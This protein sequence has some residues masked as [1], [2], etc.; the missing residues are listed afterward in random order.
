MYRAS[1]SV[2]SKLCSVHGAVTRSSTRRKRGNV[3][4]VNTCFTVR[5]VV[6][7]VPTRV[8]ASMTR[9][10][11]RQRVSESPNE[12]GPSDAAPSAPVRIEGSHATA[13]RKS[14]RGVMGPSSLS[15]V[16]FFPGPVRN[17][18]RPAWN[19]TGP[20]SPPTEASAAG[21]GASSDGGMGTGEGAGRLPGG[22][23]A[24]PA[25]ARPSRARAGDA[26]SPS[27]SFFGSTGATD[28]P[29][30]SR[31]IGPPVLTSLR[32]IEWKNG[33]SGTAG[34]EKSP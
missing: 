16:D 4:R 30:H 26:S 6:V 8:E 21:R 25:D 1:V 19:R 31:W 22:G 32:R 15:L 5:T 20:A 27:A 14:A 24:A 23:G 33:S 18:V 13:E 2:A 29:T 34:S 10:V 28:Q 17:V 3:K 9:D 7:D 12:I 11:I